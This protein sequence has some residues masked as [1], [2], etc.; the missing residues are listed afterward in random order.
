MV[1]FLNVKK[2]GLLS[3]LDNY[4]KAEPKSKYEVLRLK[5]NGVWLV[6]FDSGKLLLQ[7]EEDKSKELEKELEELG[8]EKEEELSFKEEKGEVIGSDEA[9]KGDTFGGIVVAGVKCNE[10]GRDFLREI[11]V[12]DSKTLSD[13]EIIVMAEKIKE[14]VS[15]EVIN[16]YPEEYNNYKGQTEILNKLHRQVSKYLQP[17]KHV[18]DKYPGC[19]VGNVIETHAEN[20]YIEVAAASVLARAG[21]LEQLQRLSGEAGF[22][23]PKGSSHV[24]WALEELKKKDL[25]FMYFVKLHFRNVNSIL[26]KKL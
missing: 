10:E 9:L 7:G 5:K 12:A 15:C 3:K 24:K 20:K 1:V 22:E 6:L 26:N 2:E 18:V 23:V 14:K 21:A 19:K 13:E 16:L 11:S 17:G 25:D 8:F 4:M